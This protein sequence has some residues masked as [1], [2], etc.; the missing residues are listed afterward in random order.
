MTLSQNGTLDRRESRNG[1]KEGER[2]VFPKRR[3][4]Q[5]GHFRV[6]PLTKSHPDLVVSTGILNMKSNSVQTLLYYFYYYFDYRHLVPSGF[7]WIPF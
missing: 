2:R 1:S 4:F 6:E 3:L 5:I 7:L